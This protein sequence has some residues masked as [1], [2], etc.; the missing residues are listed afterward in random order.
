MRNRCRNSKD[1]HFADYGGRGIMVCER[2]DSF[3]CFLED[4]GKRPEGTTLDRE[5]HNGNYEPKN[6][7]WSNASVQAANKRPRLAI[8]SFSDEIFL[9]EYHRRFYGRRKERKEG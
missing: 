7:R 9:G 5:N 8:E 6:C 1:K 4:M 3:V 2:W